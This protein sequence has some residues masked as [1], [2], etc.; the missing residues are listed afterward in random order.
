MALQDQ[1]KKITI[2]GKDCK[3][4]YFKDTDNIFSKKEL[5]K[6]DIKAFDYKHI[7]IVL[8]FYFRRK[9]IKKN[10]NILI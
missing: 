7:S 8:K 2:T 4:I 5:E 3:G 10:L 9:T 1:L 6:K